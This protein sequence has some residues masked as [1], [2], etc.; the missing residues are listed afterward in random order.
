MPSGEGAVVWRKWPPA[1]TARVQAYGRANGATLFM[2]LMAGWQALLARYARQR[3]V[4]VGV[5]VAQ[6]PRPELEPL[7]GFFLNT[8][9][10][11]TQVRGG[12]SWRALTTD[13]RAQAL[14]AYAHQLVPFEQV[15]A[16]LQPERQLGR[17][18]LFQVLFVLQNLPTPGE[19]PS[20]LRLEV[21]ES[22]STGAKFDLELAVKSRGD[23]LMC[24]LEYAVDLFDRE[25]SE[26]MLG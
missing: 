23:D 15:I 17:T 25:R 11:R 1:L 19:Q 13:V 7:V 8:I 26:R 24:R 22:R 12:E 16:A 3:D 14:A 21:L 10:L 6:R 2:V 20:A 9:V 4:A 18:P 5:P